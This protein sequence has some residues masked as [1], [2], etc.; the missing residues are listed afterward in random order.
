MKAFTFVEIDVDHCTLTYGV[1]PCTAAVGVTGERKCYNTLQTCQNTANYSPAPKT[2]RYAVASDD[3]IE[4]DDA[5]APAIP[6]VISVSHN[7]ARIRLG[8]DLGERASV[9]VSFSDHP[10][11]DISSDPYI[12]ERPNPPGTYWGR[13]RARHKYILGRPLRWINQYNTS[14]N[15]GGIDLPVVW[16]SDAVDWGAVGVVWNVGANQQ[17]RNYI[18]EAINGPDINGKVSIVAKDV[19]KLADG[20]TTQVPKLSTGFLLSDINNTQTSI[21]LSPVGIGDLEYDG[22]ELIAI[23][24]EILAV[25]AR[26]GNNLTVQRG[27]EFTQAESHEEGDQ[28]QFVQVYASQ[29][30]SE[31]VYDLLVTRS[32]IPATAI[33]LTKWNSDYDLFIN[34]LYSARIAEPTPAKKLISELMEQAGFALFLDE[35]QNQ[36]KLVPLRSL[37]TPSFSLSDDQM[38]AGSLTIKDQPERRISQVWVYYGQRNPLEKMDEEKNFSV[39]RLDIDLA[40]ES[41]DQ[42][43]QS[44]IRK[45][46]SRWI[47]KS[48]PDNAQSAADLLIERFR[49]PPQNFSFAL[50]VP[51]VGVSPDIGQSVNLLSRVIQDDAG[52]QISVPVT[53][54][55]RQD[56][57]GGYRIEA[58]E[59]R[60]QPL[61]PDAPDVIT[62]PDYDENETS[63]TVLRDVYN[64]SRVV[65]PTADTIITFIVPSTVTIG[66][67]TSAPSISTGSW[68][69]GA[70]VT[71]INN[72]R[73]LGKGGNGG[74]VI[75]SNVQ[76]NG[77]DGTTA[78]QATFPI[79]IINN[80][81]IG[82]GGGGGA[83][84]PINPNPLVFS[85]GGGGGA[86]RKN[87]AGGSYTNGVLVN[88]LAGADGTDTAGGAGGGFVSVGGDGGDLGQAGNSTAAGS[89]GAAGNAITGS[90]FVTLSV[91]GD[92]RG[93]QV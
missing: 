59:F 73:I 52:N 37:A 2:I 92:I 21:T 53:L 6:S 35:V 25:T 31:I 60:I 62:L 58:E 83:L 93:S 38:I 61:D 46:Y 9:T 18:I 49:N 28:V 43:G 72:G 24:D 79:T 47:P 17:V 86:G 80:N 56:D 55:S 89:G 66:G 22:V 77:T 88:I 50:Q 57:W 63:N 29:R 45:I 36:I 70:S 78:I 16:G 26:F 85:G 19:L 3:L 7:P 32:G 10:D 82:G 84:G 13:F 54:I 65:P 11:S 67:V 71:L 33:D 75:N 1:S 27:A 5:T 8:E 14:E 39:A 41:A 23:N 91:V 81:L 64:A 40:A 15:S 51:E 68:P 4:A 42:Y 12:T 87:G 74:F 76:A 48:L 34:R 20:V 30:A 44:A 90:S 69:T